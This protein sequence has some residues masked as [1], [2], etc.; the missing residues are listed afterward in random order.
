M[1][2][3]N[4]KKQKIESQ[5]NDS[6]KNNENNIPNN[7]NNNNNKP[8]QP[9]RVPVH[10]L[11]LVSDET[12]NFIVPK[13]LP[14]S[15]SI[16]KPPSYWVRKYLSN[17][18][19]LRVYEILNMVSLSV[20]QAISEQGNS[21]NKK[22]Y[23]KRV[24]QS[25]MVIDKMFAPYGSVHYA[26]S[27]ISSNV[28][29]RTFELSVLT[30]LFFVKGWINNMVNAEVEMFI[31]NLKAQV[32]NNGTIYVESNEFTIMKHYPDGSRTIKRFNAK[33]IFDSW[34][35]IEFLELVRV[36]SE[37]FAS[38]NA[39]SLKHLNQN[40]ELDQ[41]LQFIID[42]NLDKKK[43]T[44]RKFDSTN[45]NENNE[46]N[47]TDKNKNDSLPF[48]NYKIDTNLT[49]E[50][51]NPFNSDKNKESMSNSELI[52]DF[53][54]EKNQCFNLNEEYNTHTNALKQLQLADVMT[55]LKTLMLYQRINK[56]ESPMDSMFKFVN[57]LR[58]RE[59][60][61]MNK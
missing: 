27:P 40:Q 18:A 49:T 56:V 24:E 14:T 31:N 29:I 8:F 43:A 59:R 9:L 53:I 42:R 11:P 46:N 61:M 50:K 7:N 35:K 19:I 52:T 48:P 5:D 38:Q 25:I 20:K 57:D 60:D 6:T 28:K 32:L 4:N 17:M 36:K 26:I 47:L 51:N 13:P 16:L 54:K 44:K 34:L 45:D 58:K 2:G 30:F 12:R 23:S 1:N 39:L 33:V 37:S 3:Y 22:E 15:V 55:N 41:L 10:L 21:D